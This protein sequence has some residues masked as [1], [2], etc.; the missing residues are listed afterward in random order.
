MYP[1]PNQ[2]RQLETETLFKI[3]RLGTFAHFGELQSDANQHYNGLKYGRGS[4][5]VSLGLI[6]DA[7]F[8]S[9]KTTS[10]SKKRVDIGGVVEVQDNSVTRASYSMILCE[11]EFPATSNILRKFH[12]DFEPF[13]KRNDAEP[14]PNVHLQICGKLSQRQRDKG[15]TDDHLSSWFPWLE[16]PRIPVAPIS[17]AILLNWILLEFQHGTYVSSILNNPEWRNHVAAAERT[18]LLGYFKSA[19]EFLES[20]GKSSEGFF[21]N[22]LYG[23]NGG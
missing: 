6:L 1:D 11:S 2:I 15:Y 14:K 19:T 20:T 4:V 16:K 12:F 5:D 13:E 21:V 7:P 3:M 9:G 17:L 10:S 8:R 18:M 23:S 22:C